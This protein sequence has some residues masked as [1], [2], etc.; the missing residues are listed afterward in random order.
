MEESPCPHEN[1]FCHRPGYVPRD[2]D[3]FMSELAEI[4]SEFKRLTKRLKKLVKE[5]EERK[6]ELTVKSE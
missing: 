6:G 3:R 5:T 4:T 1:C 2:P